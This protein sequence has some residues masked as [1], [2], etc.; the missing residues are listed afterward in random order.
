MQ[1]AAGVINL[2]ASPDQIVE[3]NVNQFEI[4]PN[5]HGN[6]NNDIA[7]LV[8]DSPFE[9]NELVSPICLPSLSKMAK[10]EMMKLERKIETGITLS[11]SGWG[12][13]KSGVLQNIVTV[14]YSQR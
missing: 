1:I 13:G 5:F 12:D 7:I 10:L 2:R 11:V 6:R 9:Y 4:H 14:V 8:S 3:R